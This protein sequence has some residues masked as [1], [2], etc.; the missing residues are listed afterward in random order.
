MTDPLAEIVSL[1]QPQPVL[2]KVVN[3]GGTWKVH[4]PDNDQ[5]LYCVILDGTTKARAQGLSLDLERGDFVLIPSAAGF[6][7]SG[8]GPAGRQMVAEDTFTPVGD[9]FWLGDHTAPANA[10][11]MVGHF[12]F[13]SPDAALLVALLP[14]IILIRGE[15]RLATLVRLVREEAQAQRPAREVILRH[16]LEVLMI[17]A[18]RSSAHQNEDAPGLLRGLADTRLAAAI[19]SIHESPAEDWTI[20]K[21]ARVAALSRSAFF[22]RFNRTLGQAPMAYLSG[23]RMALARDMIRRRE[24]DIGQIATR[25]GYGSTSA[26]SVAFSRHVGMS[27]SRYAIE[28]A[29]GQPTHD[30]SAEYR[31]R[32]CALVAAPSIHKKSARPRLLY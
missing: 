22:D 25:V 5:P 31:A 24:A 11:F 16:L 12:T 1:L 23:W 6:E 27:P 19:R 26:F 9:E 4:R 2:T 28:T 15:E 21:L 7:M 3:G 29:A 32:Q 30:P 13:G 17:E 20:E 10:R 18:L 8:N 14:G